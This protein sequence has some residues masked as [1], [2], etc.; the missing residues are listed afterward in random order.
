MKKCHCCFHCGCGYRKG[1]PNRC[2]GLWECE[3]TSANLKSGKRWLGDKYQD[4]MFLPRANTLGQIHLEVIRSPH[5]S[6]SSPSQ[7]TEQ[8]GLKQGMDMEGKQKIACI[9][10]IHCIFNILLKIYLPMTNA[11]PSHAYFPL[12]ISKE[13]ILRYG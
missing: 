13:N 2:S 5:N 6:W 3:T 11:N 9:F 7:G 8:D 12:F 1:L 4:L 10:N